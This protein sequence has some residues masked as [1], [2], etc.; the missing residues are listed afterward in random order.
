M[1]TRDAASPS[2]PSSVSGS[3]SKLANAQVQV[4]R[5]KQSSG[6][7]LGKGQSKARVVLDRSYFTL[8]VKRPYAQAN[9][10]STALG[11]RR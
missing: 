2:I 10:E 7:A 6:D 3:S 1:P 9:T 5:T 4:T 8:P 11:H